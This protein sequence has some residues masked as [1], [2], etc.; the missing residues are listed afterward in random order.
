[1]IQGIMNR[2]ASFSPSDF[3]NQEMAE[4]YDQR[5]AG[6]KPLSDCLHFQMRLVLSSLPKQ[7]RV[8]CVGVGTGADIFALASE[9]PDLSFLGVD[10]SEEMLEVARHRL[11][12]AGIGARCELVPGYVADAPR[13]EFDAAVSLLVA[14]FVQRNDRPEFYRAIYDRLAPG[15]RFVSAEISGDLDAPGFP[16]MLEDWKQVH[17]MMGASEESLAS[18]GETLRNMLGVVGPAETEALWREAGF[19]K[20]VPFYQAFMIR[21]WHTRKP[22]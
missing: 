19:A 7:A 10:P 18:L 9:R 11:D 20:P 15:G 12:E 13:D 21:G 8:L 2:H 4:A 3:F 22:A 5:N 17:A 14:H 16:E 1:M 6:L